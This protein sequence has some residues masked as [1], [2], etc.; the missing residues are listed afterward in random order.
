METNTTNITY[1][2]AWKI[3][4]AASTETSFNLNAENNCRVDIN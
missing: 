1:Y 4:G 3:G 2:Y